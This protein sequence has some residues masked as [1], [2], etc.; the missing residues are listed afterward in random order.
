MATPV[1]VRLSPPAFDLDVD[2]ISAAITPRTRAVLVNSPHNPSGKIY[3]ES[4]L[5]ALGNVLT[6]ASERYGRPIFIVS[7]EPYNRIV[8]DGR[9]YTSPAQVYPNTIT[10]Y[11][12]GKTLLAPG[13]RIGYITVPPTMPDREELRER[14]ILAQLAN[15]YLFPNALLQ[16]A[17]DDLEKLSIDV[18]ALER[19]RDRM[20]PALRAMGYECSMPE[21]TFYLMAKAPTDDDLAFCQALG[22]E[23]R[24]GAAG[25]GGGGARM[26]PHLAHRE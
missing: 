23:R 15:G 13:M 19:R 8:F 24:A 20:V 17:I 11:S 9:T 4:A 25:H 3:S 10:T 2:A 22:R 26:V 14:I 16:H 21:G 7:D 1:R 18:G 5:R 6:A 12:Y